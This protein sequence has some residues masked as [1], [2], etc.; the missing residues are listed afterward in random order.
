MAKILVVSQTPPPFNGSTI[1][2]VRLLDAL[3][4]SGHEIQISNKRF[5]KS[6]DE[7][8][9]RYI[10]KFF[11]LP[12]F[13][14]RL[15]YVLFSSRPKIVILFLTNRP[16]S[17]AVDCMIASI[18]RL[19]RI[20]QLH[21]LHTN[22]FGE[23]A[24]RNPAFKYLL[25][26]VSHF[27]S[28]T[29]ALS[30]AMAADIRDFAPD[31]RIRIIPNCVT[32]SQHTKITDAKR[33]FDSKNLIFVS[34]LIPSKGHQDF[35]N[36]FYRLAPNYPALSGAIIG[37]PSYPHQLEEL[38]REVAD[39]GYSDRI[40]ILGH[41][42]SQ[43]IS[44]YLSESTVLVFPS[45]YA[46][47]AQPLVLLEGLAHSL[48]IVGY[49]SG[50]V[51]ETINDDTGSRMVEAGE[52]ELLEFELQRLLSDF[53]FWSQSSSKALGAYQRQHSCAEF[54]NRWESV[55]NEVLG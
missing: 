11:V 30:D 35:L 21:Y 45:Q 50:Q 9:R 26:K 24:N 43:V 31:S 52:I 54:Q 41:Q 19:L 1:M 34:N 23:L 17:F 55:L 40:Q 37:S 25:S 13:I 38:S 14:L 36:V 16:L 7:I 18:V 20:E 10:K 51:S 49:R 2:T 53:D 46:F 5:S 27:S 32:E 12:T 48:P 28:V 39:H 4:A 22:G 29:V 33:R 42:S 44:K 47:E 15:I 6:S 3:T 8:G